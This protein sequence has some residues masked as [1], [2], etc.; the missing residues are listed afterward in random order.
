M[1][2]KP[3]NRAKRIYHEYPKQFWVVVFA[4]FIDHTGGALIFPFFALYIT[5]KFNVGMTEV[6]LLFVVF[7]ISNF[8]G[9]ML[10]GALTDH[11]GRKSVIIMGL[12]VSALTSLGMGLVTKLEYFYLMAIVT[13]IFADMAG[14]AHQAMITDLLPEE[15]RADGYGIMRVAMNLSVAIGP[16]IGGFLAAKSYLLLFSTDAVTSIITAVIFYLLVA[17]TRPQTVTAEASIQPESSLVDSF[18]GYLVVWRDR[19][20]IAFLM[21]S[22]VITIVYVQMNS[23][24]AVFLRDTRGVPE[25]GFGIIMSFNAL[26]VVLF[27]FAITRRLSKHKPMLMMALGALIYAIGFSMYGYVA[28]FGMYLVAMFIITVGEMIVVP[29]AQTVVAKFSPEDMRGRYMAVF[30]ISW[31]IPGSVGPLL[32]GLVMDNADPL[33]VWYGAGILALVAM[34][35]FLILH[36]SQDEKPVSAPEIQLDT[37]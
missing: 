10:G 5:H 24:L 15:K 28:N 37:V 7:G 22:I 31:L 34:F 36:L 27:Q 23:T 30:G 17:E 4:S 13:G 2:A 16:A 25:S 9:S 8:I 29:V 32:A 14:P 20:F 21:I 6:G 11:M 1:L 35:G 19:A 12:I 33:W 26:L 3:I 18:K